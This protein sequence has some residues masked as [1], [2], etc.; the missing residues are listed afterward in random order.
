MI[1]ALP[2]EPRK[3]S[4]AATRHLHGRLIAGAVLALVIVGGAFVWRL[5][6][7]SPPPVV[8]PVA[9]AAP[10]RN[11]VLDQLVETTKALED[12]QQQAIDQLQVLQQLVASQKAEARKS[13]DEV[14]ALS[15][16]LESLRQSFASVP[17]PSPEEAEASQPR[18]PKA[19]VARSPARAH[20]IVP[21][22]ARTATT[23]H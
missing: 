16:K 5:T 6:A 17:P 12:S 23:R 21:G 2:S 7:N 9:S 11:P 14:A 19:T 8:R 4:A 20:R 22:N 15:D 1:D 10:A 3:D 13:S 18:K